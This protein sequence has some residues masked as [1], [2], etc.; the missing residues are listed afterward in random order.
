M[1]ETN[2]SQFSYVTFIHTTPA[3]LWEAL[4]QPQLVRRYWFGITV[5]CAWTKGSPWKLIGSDGSVFDSGEI[6]DIEPARRVVIRWTNQWKPELHA[7]GPSRCTFELEAIDRAV[8]LTV[9]HEIERPDSKLIAAVAAGWPPVLS[10]L[11]SLLETSEIAVAT[12][13]GH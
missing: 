5:E 4:T 1:N 9:T 6:V 12:H 11:K 8:K 3:K 10:N 7:E 2:R 13:P